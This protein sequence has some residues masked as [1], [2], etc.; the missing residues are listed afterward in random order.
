MR[1]LLATA[2]IAT[3]VLLIAVA[4][5]GGE[6]RLRA[7]GILLGVNDNSA[8]E[9]TA[10][11]VD[12][13]RLAKRVGADVVRVTL[14]WRS[15]EPHPGEFHWRVYDRVAAALARQ[16]LRPVWTLLF[17]PGWARDGVCTNEERNC[18]DPPTA[19]HDDAWRALARAVAQRFPQSA[20][21]EVWNEPNVPGFWGPAPDPARYARLL[22]LAHE[23]VRE[24]APAVP[25]LF[26]GIA[27]VV[28]PGEAGIPP[29][30]F[31]ERV[32][33]AGARDA[34]DGI[35]IHPYPYVQD[36]GPVD[37]ML[38]EVR[39]ARERI[40]R[41]DVRLWVTE[42]GLSTEGPAGLA[43]S[44]GL[45]AQL[46]VALTQH[47]ADQRGVHAVILYTLID[48]LHADTL[49]QG[50]GI[51]GRSLEPK[52]AFCALAESWTGKDAC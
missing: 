43:V 3:G 35:S 10:D 5:F 48:P 11:S 50:F 2:L 45:Q 4:I 1:G 25:V 18:I 26:G 44:P 46:L 20:A 19:A 15:L 51:V 49:E 9:K 31:I 29:G 42:T 36:F 28:S 13:A 41:H 21:I 34:F 16:G 22:T 40:G 23:G 33:A 8:R 52:P 38:D 12:A 17:A 30:A 32:A 24:V 37:R 27:N 6:P 14:D 47:L 7:P 39:S